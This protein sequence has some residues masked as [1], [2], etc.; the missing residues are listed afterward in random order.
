MKNSIPQV[1]WS[2]WAWT[3]ENGKEATN[4]Q[5]GGATISLQTPGDGVS[6]RFQKTCIL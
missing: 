3:M 2:F 6:R 4:A 5:C 1:A